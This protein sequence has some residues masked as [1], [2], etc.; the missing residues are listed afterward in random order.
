MLPPAKVPA[1]T[2]PKYTTHRFWKH[3]RI[4]SAEGRPL[5]ESNSEGFGGVT[6][7]T[8]VE[9]L[10]HT[11]AFRLADRN[12]PFHTEDFL[13]IMRRYTR[14]ASLT[15]KPN[16][17]TTPKRQQRPTFQPFIISLSFSALNLT[18][19]DRQLIPWELTAQP[20]RRCLFAPPKK[21]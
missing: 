8:M 11:P 10:P 16:A 18:S 1:C 3:R 14:F 7:C 4:C 5:V 20:S 9:N 6:S 12:F 19:I 2:F 21:R 15:D 17:L 13:A